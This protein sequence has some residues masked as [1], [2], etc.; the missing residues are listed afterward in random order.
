ME[1][2]TPANKSRHLL[3][4]SKRVTLFEINPLISKVYEEG[5]LFSRVEVTQ[6]NKTKV[7][8]KG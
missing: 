7:I 3:L 5:Q 1:E 6:N 2:T 8:K 4:I